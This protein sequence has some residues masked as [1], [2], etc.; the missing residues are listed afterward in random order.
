MEFHPAPDIQDRIEKIVL[1]TDLVYIDSKKVKCFRSFG[2]KSKARGRIWSFPRIWQQALKIKPHY[3]IEVISEKFDKLNFVDQEK[4]LIH[5]LLHI[6]KNFSGSLLPHRG[7]GRA[8]NSLKVNK[9]FT[10][11]YQK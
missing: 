9:L 10:K 2:S 7:R 11:L 6:P 1:K 3:I 5:E 8:I 4:I